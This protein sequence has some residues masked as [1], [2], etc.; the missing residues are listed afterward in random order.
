MNSLDNRKRSVRAVAPDS[1]IKYLLEKLE[2]IRF[3]VKAKKITDRQ[4]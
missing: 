4:Q 2:E 3:T 1:Y